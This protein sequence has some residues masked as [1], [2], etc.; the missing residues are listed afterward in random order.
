M[1]LGV[2]E[3][4]WW[5]DGNNSIK[6]TFDTLAGIIDNN[7]FGYH[8]EMFNNYESLRELLPRVVANPQ[9]RHLYIAAHGDETSIYGANDNRISR[10][11]LINMI[12]QFHARQLVGIYFG[13][14]AFGEQTKYIIESTKVSWVAGFSEDVDWMDCAALDLF[15]WNAY[16]SSSVSKA[17]QV[18][19]RSRRMLSFLFALWIRIPYMFVEMGFKV[20]LL[21]P[22]KLPR[23]VCITFPEDAILD[24]KGYEI[25]NEYKEIFNETENLIS[26]QKTLGSWP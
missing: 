11:V 8:Y 14:C 16:Y 7:P 15:F 26:K 19:T 5:K 18:K 12:K 1:D 23:R 13:S 25:K 10:T 6:D 3:T 2:I 22:E 21:H 24:D 20:S 17:R 4:R 9:I